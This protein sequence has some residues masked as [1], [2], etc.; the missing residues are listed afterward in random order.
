MSTKNLVTR[1]K[2]H[3]HSTSYLIH[4]VH[5]G[6]GHQQRLQRFRRHI[7]VL[8]EEMQRRLLV[9]LQKTPPSDPQTLNVI[10]TTTHRRLEVHVGLGRQ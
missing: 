7:V 4:Q 10:S 1:I 5:V 9:I 8:T 6:L 3:H 2:P